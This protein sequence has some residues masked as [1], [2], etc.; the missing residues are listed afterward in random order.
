VEILKNKDYFNKKYMSFVAE[1]YKK[2]NFIK[3]IK[4]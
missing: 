2:N 1:I 3:D 4:I